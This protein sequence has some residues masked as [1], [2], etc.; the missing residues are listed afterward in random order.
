MRHLDAITTRLVGKDARK[1]FQRAAVACFANSALGVVVVVTLFVGPD[2]VHVALALTLAGLQIFILLALAALL[3]HQY[4]YRGGN[5]WVL[6]M[7][8]AVLLT[9]AI[10]VAEG[11][12]IE[13]YLLVSFSLPVY[14]VFQIVLL[15][16]LIRWGR[17]V[18]GLLGPYCGMSIAGCALGAT[19]VLSWLCAPVLFAAE[20]VLGVL[21]YRVAIALTEEEQIA[22]T[23]EEQTVKT[24]LTSGLFA[25]QL[26]L[27]GLIV[28][29]PL[30]VFVLGDNGL[31]PRGQSAT[32]VCLGV[33]AAAAVVQLVAMVA[34]VFKSPSVFQGIVSVASGVVSALVVGILVIL[35]LLLLFASALR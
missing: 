2:L 17:S 7:M 26:V 6:A 22:L 12:V 21:F 16:K 19:I 29:I 25:A 8:G 32:Y 1:L 5:V 34:M 13:W 35:A 24:S 3:T 20:V 9:V 30:T 11:P 33:V 15:I 27:A 14:G 28:L 31:G 23:E 4:D 18:Y 10:L